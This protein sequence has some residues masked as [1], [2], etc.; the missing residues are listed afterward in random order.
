MSEI[1]YTGFFEYLERQRKGLST[2]QCK[3]CLEYIDVEGE[4]HKGCGTDT[5]QIGHYRDSA[6]VYNEDLPKKRRKRLKRIVILIAS[7][8]FLF[9]SMLA[10]IWIK[11]IP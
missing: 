5:T 4:P 1:D 8:I 9:V 3:D 6:F 11:D 7:F 2:L 10:G